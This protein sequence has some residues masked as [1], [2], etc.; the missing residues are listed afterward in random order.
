MV[1]RHT[2]QRLADTAARLMLDEGIRDYGRA[3][4][5]ASEQLGLDPRAESPTNSEIEQA[6]LERSRLFSGDAE[7]AEYQARLRAAVLVMERLSDFQPRL[8][9]PLVQ[10][11]VT[12]EPLI[13][14]HGFAETVEEVIISLDDRGISCHSGERRYRQAN[15]PQ[16]LRVPFLSFQGP[17]GLEIQLT[18]FPLIGLRQ[19]P[20]SPVD[21]RPMQRLN[22]ASVKALLEDVR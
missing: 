20:A 15:R 8:V 2:R 3:K 6:L 14:L 19:P 22:L 11:I 21:G 4:R 7:Q 13:Y 9:G 12:P 1:E 16:P 17:D 5:K 18:I 10:G